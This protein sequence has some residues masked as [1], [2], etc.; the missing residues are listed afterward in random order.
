MTRDGCHSLLQC[1]TGLGSNRA[2]D[3]ML[4]AGC[5]WFYVV[6]VAVVVVV[7]VIAVAI[8]VVA[9]VVVGLLSQ[10]CPGFVIA[11]VVALDSGSEHHLVC[12]FPPLFWPLSAHVEKKCKKTSTFKLHISHLLT[13]RDR[14]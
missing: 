8:A 2:A 10:V 4:L 7:V 11:Q 12:L 6:V 5:C 3:W 1:G 14:G 13:S 9:V